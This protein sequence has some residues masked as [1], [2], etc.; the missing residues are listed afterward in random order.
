MFNVV[1]GTFH[2]NSNVAT[3]IEFYWK[4]YIFKTIQFKFNKFLQS[5][6][7]HLQVVIY[8]L[9]CFKVEHARILYLNVIFELKLVYI[10]IN[11]PR[12]RC[13]NT[14]DVRSKRFHFYGLHSSPRV[15]YKYC[16][17]DGVCWMCSLNYIPEYCHFS[18]SQ[19]RFL[20]LLGQFKRKLK[21]KWRSSH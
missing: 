5:I 3:K 9:I 19:N 13:V 6:Y 15:H 4:T 8:P 2:K 18:S 1:F 20:V 21:K 12:N 14:W 7:K 10:D 11:I 17:C 16:Y